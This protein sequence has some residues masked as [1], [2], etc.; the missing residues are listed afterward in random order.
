VEW[1]KTSDDDASIRM[2]VRAVLRCLEVDTQHQGV[3][4]KVATCIGAREKDGRGKGR[5]GCL[6]GC[7]EQGGE[8]TGAGT[9]TAATWE[10][11]RGGGLVGAASS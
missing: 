3:R 5:R 11:E 4:R 9:G 1:G 2:P 8:R 10:E 6:S 7:Y